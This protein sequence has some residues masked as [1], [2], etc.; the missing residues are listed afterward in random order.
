MLTVWQLEESW[1]IQEDEKNWVLP[2][3]DGMQSHYRSNDERVQKVFPGEGK[4][5]LTL[6]ELHVAVGD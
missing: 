5:E 2:S 1:R 6:K 3:L 4:G